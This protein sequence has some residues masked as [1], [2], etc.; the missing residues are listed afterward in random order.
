MAEEQLPNAAE[1]QNAEAQA[2]AD[3][4]GLLDGQSTQPG[5][6]GQP[7]EELSELDKYKKETDARLSAMED[8]HRK[9][10]AKLGRQKIEQRERADALQRE[11]IEMR[12]PGPEPKPEHFGGMTQEYFAAKAQYD[13][14]HAAHQQRVNQT[15]QENTQRAV[16][17]SM[18]ELREAVTSKFGAD[19]QKFD[20]I[21]NSPVM[22]HPEM[23]RAMSRSSDGADMM[24]HFATYPDDAA[25]ITAAISAGDLPSARAMMM[26][27]SNHVRSAGSR[28][29]QPIATAA[30]ETGS[31]SANG[32]SGQRQ[33]FTP[34]PKSG[35]SARVPKHSSQ[36]T[37]DDEY[38]RLRQE[39]RKRAKSS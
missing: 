24:L 19:K 27:V 28:V 12:G 21:M 4:S 8:R 31:G 23:F 17:E 26:A 9:E 6:D 39:E 15:Q 1:E 25:Q 18:E 38:M 20:L 29:A 37:S 11:L 16:R 7:A 2:G 13:G 33:E 36:A 32:T 14:A 22:I 5:A 35:G 30:A 3:S 10:L 34:S